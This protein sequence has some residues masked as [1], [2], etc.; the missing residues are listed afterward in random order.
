[1]KSRLLGA[2]GFFY[3]KFVMKDQSVRILPMVYFMD[4]S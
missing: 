2:D 4:S 1:M 3:P